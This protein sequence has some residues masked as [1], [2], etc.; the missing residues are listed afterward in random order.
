M[1][2]SFL[3]LA[4]P[5]VGEGV[6]IPYE[7]RPVCETG[8]AEPTLRVRRWLKGQAWSKHLPRGFLWEVNSYIFA[9]RLGA[10][11]KGNGQ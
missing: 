8:P 7:L 2:G 5:L 1:H 9:T 3:Q 6:L 4:Q 11:V 10:F